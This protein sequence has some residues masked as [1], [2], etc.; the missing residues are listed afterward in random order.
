M[1]GS[2]PPSVQFNVRWNS[3][4]ARC[5]FAVWFPLC[6]HAATQLTAAEI[7]H[8]SVEANERDW[9]AGPSF[10]HVERDIDK[11][12]NA[13]VDR[14][15][16]VFLMDGSPYKRLIGIDGHPLSEAR[17]KQE[18]DRES[19]ELARRRAETPSERR[20]R[21]DRYRRDR[22][23][24]HI[25]MTQMEVAFNFHL[26]GEG[27]WSG[28][29]VYVLDA[30][31]KP[32]Y[33]PPNHEAKVLTGMKGKLWVDKAGFHWARVEAEVVH[34][35]T[36]AGF[37]ARVGPG[38]RF[39][40]EKEPVNAEIWQPQRFQDQV[41]ASILFWQR[42]SSTADTFSDYRPNGAISSLP[43]P[44]RTFHVQ[45]ERQKIEQVLQRQ[46]RHQPAVIDHQ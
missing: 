25:L 35:V 38:T 10:S 6:S 8:R 23:H 20:V 5:A 1:Q 4:V 21:I 41:V 34:T 17:Q 3:C 18:A 9:K 13:L 28:H 43:G 26:T 32:D 24:D 16:E 40:L 36:F 12:D 19:H 30:E 11:H 39:I 14:T 7:I 42:N 44:R 33:V 27:T 22:E 37:L 2:R 15:W 29:P 45:L 46:N 31:P